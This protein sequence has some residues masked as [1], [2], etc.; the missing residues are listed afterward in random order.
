[1]PLLRGTSISHAG[2]TVRVS[3]DRE[4]RFH[5]IVSSDFRGS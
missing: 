4:Q 3:R 5:R 2:F 1:L